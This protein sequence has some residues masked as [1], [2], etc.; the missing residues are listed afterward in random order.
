[1]MH[2]AVIVICTVKVVVVVA[3]SDAL[4]DMKRHAAAISS[5]GAIRDIIG[6]NKMMPTVVHYGI[7]SKY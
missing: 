7:A 2:D 4:P 3:E 6:A 1:M 5:F